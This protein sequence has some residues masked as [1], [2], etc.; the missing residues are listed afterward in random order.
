MDW[1]LYDISLR[2]ERVK[3]TF[4]KVPCNYHIRRGNRDT[5][6]HICGGNLFQ[7]R[8]Q[9]PRKHPRWRSL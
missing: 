4:L 7:R 6:E 1:F 2:H 3:E 9:D 8:S 5:S